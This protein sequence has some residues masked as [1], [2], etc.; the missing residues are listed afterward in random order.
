MP[1]KAA[2][3]LGANVQ[4]TAGHST[5]LPGG[6]VLISGPGSSNV[7]I[8]GR[9]AIRASLDR[10]AP[11]SYDTG[12]TCTAHTTEELIIPNNPLVTTTSVFVNGFPMVRIGDLVEGVLGKV[13]TGSTNVYAG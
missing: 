6:F 12:P 3:F 1:L 9:N 5:C 7:K 8:N 11:H 4:L 2:T 10:I 13:F